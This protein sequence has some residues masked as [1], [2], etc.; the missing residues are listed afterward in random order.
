MKESNKWT[1]ELH[2]KYTCNGQT[3][4]KTD[5]IAIPPTDGDRTDL[6]TEFG[7][8][9]TYRYNMSKEEFMQRISKEEYLE[10]CLPNLND[11]DKKKAMKE[12]NL[13]PRKYDGQIALIIE[14][15][16]GNVTIKGK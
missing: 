13:T 11:K 14:I 5:L 9:R 7:G 4:I 2:D 8:T 6:I 1:I 10:Q 15:K 12:I 3:I 16:N